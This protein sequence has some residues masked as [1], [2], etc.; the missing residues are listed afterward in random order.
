METFVLVTDVARS[1]ITTIFLIM[2]IIAWMSK[3]QKTTK[4]K[5]FDKAYFLVI[6]TYTIITLMCIIGRIIQ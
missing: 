6:F 1:I 5:L 2:A 3:Y 4:L